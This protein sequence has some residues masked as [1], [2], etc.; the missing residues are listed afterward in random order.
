MSYTFQHFTI[1]FLSVTIKIFTFV[2]KNE[3]LGH[4]PILKYCVETPVQLVKI[5]TISA[6][7]ECM[8]TQVQTCGKK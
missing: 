8:A 4:L 6:Y 5:G 2:F 3:N 1:N 7:P